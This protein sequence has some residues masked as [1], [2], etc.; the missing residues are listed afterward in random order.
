MLCVSLT[1]YSKSAKPSFK[2][3]VL[4]L[5]K[6]KHRTCVTLG[7]CE[8]LLP[9]DCL[10]PGLR[11]QGLGTGTKSVAC[12]FSF[13]SGAWETLLSHRRETAPRVRC[14]DGLLRLCLQQLPCNQSVN[15]LACLPLPPRSDSTQWSLNTMTHCWAL[16]PCVGA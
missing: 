10:F 2:C 4:F 13:T 15:P 11:P 3:F 9:K 8:C 1:L 6:G 5:E 16:D 12:N 14:G 7:P